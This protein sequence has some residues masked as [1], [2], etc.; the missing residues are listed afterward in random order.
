MGVVGGHCFQAVIPLIRKSL[1]WQ[2]GQQGGPPIIKE[3]SRCVLFIS[4]GRGDGCFPGDQGT[5]R[6]FLEREGIG[7][8]EYKKTLV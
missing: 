3:G 7:S 1:N 6:V 5:G 2:G 8:G 4:G